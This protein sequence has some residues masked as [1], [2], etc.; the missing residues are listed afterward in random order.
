M[1]T[2]PKS[3]TQRN[4]TAVNGRLL[5][6]Q[7][8]TCLHVTYPCVCTTL[9]YESV[10]QQQSAERWRLSTGRQAT[11]PVGLTAGRYSWGKQQTKRDA[12]ADISRTCGGDRATQSQ[13]GEDRSNCRRGYRIVLP[14]CSNTQPERDSRPL[15]AKRRPSRR[16]GKAGG[17]NTLPSYVPDNCLRSK[18]RPLL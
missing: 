13:D 11:R 2:N 7:F 16:H 10:E 15:L 14:H 9:I 4:R 18:P 5:D 17:L 3:A 6:V 1:D 12:L 8:D